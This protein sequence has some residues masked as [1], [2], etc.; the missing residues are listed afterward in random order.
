VHAAEQSQRERALELVVEVAIENVGQQSAGLQVIGRVHK[1]VAV[2]RTSELAAGTSLQPQHP[3]GPR[4][5]IAAT[6]IP[7]GGHADTV[8]ARSLAGSHG[9]V[10]AVRPDPASRTGPSAYEAEGP[11]RT[12]P[13]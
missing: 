5:H 13:A 12:H 10:P 9:R 3:R 7:E 8:G 6:R 11:V 1:Q 2:Q 4:L